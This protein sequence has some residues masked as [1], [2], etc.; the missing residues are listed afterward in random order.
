MKLPDG[1]FGSRVSNCSFALLS[2]KFL[3]HRSIAVV[4][5]SSLNCSM[6]VVARKSIVSWFG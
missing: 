6:I 5:C 2:A 3:R 4:A 1:S